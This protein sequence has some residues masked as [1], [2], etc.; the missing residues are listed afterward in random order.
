MTR[1]D[2]S[3]PED[4]LRV[5]RALF[6]VGRIATLEEAHDCWWEFSA[7]VRASWLGL[8]SSDDDLAQTLRDYL[9]RRELV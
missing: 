1:H 8:P 9:H 6:L 5:Q 3:F 2:F 7:E 4:V